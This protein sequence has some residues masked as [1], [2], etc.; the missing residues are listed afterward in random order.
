MISPFTCASPITCPVLILPSGLHGKNLTFPWSL[1]AVTYLVLLLDP[2]QAVLPLMGRLKEA[3]LSMLA[4][5]KMGFTHKAG[6]R[7]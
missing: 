6:R 3:V 1:E 2:S 5:L 4:P 7:R